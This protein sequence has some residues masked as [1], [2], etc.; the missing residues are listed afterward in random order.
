M[1]V[2]AIA[3]NSRTASDNICDTETADFSSVIS[4]FKSS[5]YFFV[6]TLSVFLFQV[7]AF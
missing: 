6:L 2:V 5:V 4:S 7:G 1:N 3:G